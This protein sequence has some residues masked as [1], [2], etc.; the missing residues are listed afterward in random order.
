MIIVGDD[1]V[2]IVT[3]PKQYTETHNWYGGVFAAMISGPHRD[4]FV[5]IFESVNGL[6]FDQW[7]ELV[8]ENQIAAEKVKLTKWW[9]FRSFCHFE[10]SFDQVVS[11]RNLSANVLLNKSLVYYLP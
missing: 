7:R 8:F 5:V 2:S 4:D 11:A 9:K 1:K 10:S 3:D 6:V